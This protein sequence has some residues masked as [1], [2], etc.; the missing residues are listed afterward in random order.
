MTIPVGATS[1][2]K[3]AVPTET[4]YVI[5]T[6]SD[7]STEILWPESPI[8]E[9]E[10]QARFLQK[11]EDYVKVEAVPAE[12]WLDQEKRC[13][14]RKIVDDILDDMGDEVQT[15]NIEFGLLMRDEIRNTNGARI[16]SGLM[17]GLLKKAHAAGWEGHRRYAAE[18]GDAVGGEVPT[19]SG[20]AR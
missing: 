2:T 12:E 19:S 13:A 9:A 14:P 8:K 1:A 7:G 11:C 4:A 18:Q 3:E 15:M 17:Y 16:R 20:L 6:R 10:K 5:G